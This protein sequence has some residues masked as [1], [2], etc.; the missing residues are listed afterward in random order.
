MSKRWYVVEGGRVV[1][2]C[3]ERNLQKAESF[4]LDYTNDGKVV[5]AE[6][7]AEA[8]EIAANA[9]HQKG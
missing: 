5:L 4:S 8:V 7:D 1:Y 6:T 2:S 3:A 9:H